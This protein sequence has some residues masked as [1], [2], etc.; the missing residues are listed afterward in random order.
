MQLV[1]VTGLDPRGRG[2]LLEAVETLTVRAYPMVRGMPAGRSEVE[3]SRAMWRERSGNGT[4]VVGPAMA[5]STLSL[6]KGQPA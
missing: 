6:V 2:S 1:M 4:T 5:T 3:A